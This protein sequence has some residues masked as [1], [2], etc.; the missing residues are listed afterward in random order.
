MKA[1]VP[2]VVRVDLSVKFRSFGIT[3]GTLSRTWA[4]TLPPMDVVWQGAP[5]IH[6]NERGVRLDVWVE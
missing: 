1:F 2:H 3:F 6:L 4:L 5:S